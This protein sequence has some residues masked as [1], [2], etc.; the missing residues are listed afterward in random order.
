M[1][2]NKSST[3]EY[4]QIISCILDVGELLLKNGAE[5]MRVEDTIT[6]LCDAYGF[7][8]SDVLTIT[9][10]ILLTAVAPNG[11][12]ITQTRRIKSRSTDLSLVGRVNALSRE[13]AAN[14]MPSDKF[15]NMLQEAQNDKV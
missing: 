7:S 11:D 15:T 4:R 5:V 14:P 9:S 13:I 1:D 10:S 2:Q 6:R 12:I 8:S 3:K